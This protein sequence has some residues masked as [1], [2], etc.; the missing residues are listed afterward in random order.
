MEWLE[1]HNVDPWICEEIAKGINGD[2][3]LRTMDAA[4]IRGTGAKP[5]ATEHAMDLLVRL[6]EAVGLRHD[7]CEQLGSVKG[8]KA[9]VYE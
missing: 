3:F 8:F 7:G 5:P 6:R 1:S 2:R 4:T 9:R